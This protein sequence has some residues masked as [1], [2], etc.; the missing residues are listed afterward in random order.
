MK[1]SG[2]LPDAAATGDAFYS[3]WVA[4]CSSNG[5]CMYWF[6]VFDVVVGIVD[7]LQQRSDKTNEHRKIPMKNQIRL[8]YYVASG[9]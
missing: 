6:D 5:E 1:F 8:H 3:T 9:K 4:R 2:I 7:S